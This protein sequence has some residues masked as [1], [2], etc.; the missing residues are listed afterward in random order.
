MNGWRLWPWRG[1]LLGSVE[2]LSGTGKMHSRIRSRA[3]LFIW[4][5]SHQKHISFDVVCKFSVVQVYLK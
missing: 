2:I 4:F 5:S 1:R 3:V